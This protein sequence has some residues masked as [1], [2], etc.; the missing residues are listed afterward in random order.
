LKAKVLRPGGADRLLEGQTLEIQIMLHVKRI[1]WQPS[2]T[3][4]SVL[5]RTKMQRLST[6]QPIPGPL[7]FLTTPSVAAPQ[8]LHDRYFNPALGQIIEGEVS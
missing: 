7:A 8:S 1:K 3:S 5:Q 6:F 2:W 4:K